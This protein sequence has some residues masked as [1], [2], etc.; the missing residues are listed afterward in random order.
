MSATI[1]DQP[2]I[3]LINCDDLGY[4][5]PGCYG[6]QV[7][8]T[9][10]LDRMAREGIR[11]T[12]FYMPAPVC[13]PS[14]GGMMT[15]CYPPRI[16]FGMF[17]GRWVLLP[18]HPVGLNPEEITFPKLLQSQGY[19]TKLVGKWHCG[20]QAPFLPTRHGFD[21]YF[22]LPF[23]NDMGRQAKGEKASKY[24]PL[25]LMR[26]EAV[27]QEQ[28]D[29][30]SLTE[31]YVQESVDF[32]RANKDRPFFLYL[33]HMYVHTPLFVP[34]VF[35]RGSRNFRY[36]AAVASIDWSVGAL[37]HELEALGIDQNTLII[38]T[39]DNGSARWSSNGGLRGKK[40]TTWEGGMRVP[41]IMRWPARIPA[42][43]TC[44]KIATA[45]DF[46]PTFAALAGASL[47]PDRTVDGKDIRPL[48]FS[49]GSSEGPNEEFFY[50][51]SNRL[52]AV[53]VGK[54]KLHVGKKRGKEYMGINE[55]YD[56]EA[57]PGETTNLYDSQPT[58]VADLMRRLEACRE[59]LGDEAEGVVGKNV[60]PAGRVSNPQHL[61]RYDPSHP[62]IVAQYDLSD[63]DY[64][65][66]PPID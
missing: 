53:R 27:I 58:V 36:G 61:T 11:F 13:S 47:P 66:N 26:G 9:P 41:C 22:G 1:S 43:T 52:E 55:L 60:R 3:I 42:G 2:N 15:G 20:D 24:P 21:E 38:F 16:G 57:D 48:L 65:E 14:R 10:V 46:Y 59:D 37:L 28:P 40:G 17:E 32:L 34:E 6:S 29:Q 5:D 54:W 4:G 39:S 64:Y 18:G 62:Y 25:P 44:T 45:M 23:S 7:H 31:R 35:M 30:T 33:A 56:L 63:Q 12:D 8:A 50:Y 49:G 19:R 51:M